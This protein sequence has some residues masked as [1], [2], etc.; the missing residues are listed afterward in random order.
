[1][2]FADL[3]RTLIHAAHRL[4]PASQE[5]LTSPLTCVETREGKPLSFVTRP[6]AVEIRR[7]LQRGLLVPVTARSV[8]QYRRVRLP[9]PEPRLALVANGGR[10]LRDG[11][12]DADHSR[13][14]AGLIAESKPYPEFLRAVRAFGAEPFV[15]SLRGVEELLVCLVLEPSQVPRSWLTDA[16]GFAAGVGWTFVLQ[17]RK[18]Y[19]L[20]ARLAKGVAAKHVAATLGIG[21]FIAAGDASNDASLLEAA[22]AAIIPAHGDLVPSAATLGA[23][24][25]SAHGALAGEEIVTWAVRALGVK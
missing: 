19:F 18:A 6:A 16:Q 21:A 4:D 1:M 2:F 17:G 22:T 11:E 25:T 9:G 10:L 7:L 3:D 23:I 24:V 13:M 8:G 15:V 20:P 12:I 5:A 14:V